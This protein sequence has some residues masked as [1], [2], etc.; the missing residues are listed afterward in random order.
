MALAGATDKRTSGEIQAIITATLEIGSDQ[1]GRSNILSVHFTERQ[2]N[3]TVSNVRRL[4]RN[5]L[6]V[7]LGCSSFRP[8]PIRL[9]AVRGP[10]RNDCPGCCQLFHDLISLEISST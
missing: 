1:L 5:E 10:D 7:L 3:V 4:H 8:Y 2:R 9:D 6:P